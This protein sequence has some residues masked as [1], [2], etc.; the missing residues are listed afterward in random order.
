MESQ[1]DK[2]YELIKKIGYGTYGSV[3]EVINIHTK[4]IFACK[5]ILITDDIPYTLYNEL[6]A[7]KIFKHPNI[8]QIM[9]V[10]TERIDA[11][12]YY[13][14]I[15]MEKCE[16]SLLEILIDKH[17]IFNEDQRNRYIEQMMN[18][19]QY[20]W[21]QG[22]VHNDLSLSNILIKNDQIKIIDFGFMYNK[23][24]KQY[25][26]HKITS[27]IQPPELISGLSRACQT[28]KIDTWSLA[29]IY[30][31][32]CYNEILIRWDSK[33]SYFLDLIT[34]IGIPSIKLMRNYRLCKKYLSIYYQL[35][36]GKKLENNVS[37]NEDFFLSCLYELIKYRNTKNPCI[38][39]LS[40]KTRENKF[41]KK[42]INWNAHT[43]PNIIETIRVYQK[44][45]PERNQYFDH[46]KAK[47]Y[48]TIT[49]HG[50]KALWIGLLNHQ[51]LFEN[52]IY[53]RIHLSETMLEHPKYQLKIK[54]MLLMSQ[55]WS[56]NIQHQRNIKTICYKSRL[57]KKSTIM[58]F[59]ENSID[60]FYSMANLIY[61]HEE[62]LEMFLFDPNSLCILDTKKFQYD[63]INVLDHNIIFSDAY[64]LYKAS[65][66]NM[67]YKKSFKILYYLLLSSPLISTLDPKEIYHAILLLCIAYQNQNLRAILINQFIKLESL[68]NSL[69]NTKTPPILHSSTIY[70]QNDIGI[71]PNT[72]T[73]IYAYYFIW[74]ISK[75]PGALTTLKLKF[76][77]FTKLFQY[78]KQY[79]IDINKYYQSLNN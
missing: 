45:Y 39:H 49:E 37:V 36:L 76:P 18:A 59:L 66:I 54:S 3:Y 50:I 19:L 67:Q 74:M 6:I 57:N 41:I 15:I 68:I 72:Q 34:R 47:I 62:N 61:F 65:Q 5:K 63:F 56:K 2:N 26:Y 8:I 64:D 29:Q 53:F 24:S 4:Q 35:I 9:E 20:M 25:H 1:F 44:I 31:A 71:N 33:Y 38:D 40:N 17:Q 43:R 73:I 75:I 11:N 30:Y 52:S 27:Y 48:H 46:K 51:F 7:R 14:Y 55:I 32:M 77:G 16:D 21:H 28:D 70:H 58:D 10:I 23:C 69:L 60:R 79:Q 13:C 22:Y 42:L 78:I 12:K